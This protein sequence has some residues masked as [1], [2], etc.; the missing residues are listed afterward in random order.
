MDII[1]KPG[2]ED[3]T[4]QDPGG[5][6]YYVGKIIANNSQELITWM[7]QNNY[8][9]DVWLVSDQGNPH[10]ITDS[11]LRDVK[12]TTQNDNLGETPPNNLSSFMS[13]KQDVKTAKT[14]KTSFN[15]SAHKLA[16]KK[17]KGVD[18]KGEHFEYNPWAVCAKN[19]SKKEDPE[20]YEKCVKDVK[21]Q[22]RKKDKSKK[23]S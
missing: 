11:I 6:F 4:C 3:V 23:K 10:L 22:D 19:I 18:Y 17:E 5:P 16:K 9:P 20:K 8:F 2:E 21:D 12:D 1:N 15:L 13:S 14:K 7:K